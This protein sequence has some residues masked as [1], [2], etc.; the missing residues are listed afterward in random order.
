MSLGWAALGST[1]LG[2]GVEDSGGEVGTNHTILG[3]TISGCTFGI[4]IDTV[5]TYTLNDITFADNGYD[6]NVTA[7]S[8]TV[9]IITNVAGIAYQTAGATVVILA[10]GVTLKMTVKDE[11]GAFIVGAY[12][13]I[14][15]NNSEPYI[16]NTTTDSGGEVSVDHSEG[17]V[18]DSRWRVRKYGYKPYT[19]LVDIGSENISIP[20]TLIADPQQT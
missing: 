14:D 13:Y 20:I 17:F 5:G 3:G 4:E 15:D 18:S 9:T 10:P 6:I 2:A 7:T 19:S 11:S 12:A 8:G 16:L 1:A